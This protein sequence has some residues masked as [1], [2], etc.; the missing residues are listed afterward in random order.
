MSAHTIARE[1]D[2][3]RV[4][5]VLNAKARSVVEVRTRHPDAV[6]TVHT[7]NLCN[8]SDRARLVAGLPEQQQSRVG[9]LLLAVAAEAAASRRQAADA[10]SATRAEDSRW[11]ATE[12]HSEKQDGAKLLRDVEKVLTDH[13]ILPPGVA[14]VV[15]V[16]ALHTWC[17]DAADYTPYLWIR[18]PT[19]ECGKSTL[20][21]WLDVLVWK[22][23]GTNNASPA[24][25][26]RLIEKHGCTLLLDDIDTAYTGERRDDMANILN[27][28]FHRGSPV[29]RMEKDVTGQ[30]TDKEFATFGAKAIGGIGRRVLKGSTASRTIRVDMRRAGRDE[31]RALPRPRDRERKAIGAILRPRMMRWRDDNLAALRTQRPNIP[32]TLL[33]RASDMADPLLAIADLCAEEWP[34]RM[35][36]LLSAFM[37]HAVEVAEAT[38]H[39]VTLLRD[40]DALFEERRADFL[41]SEELVAGLK[42]LAERPWVDWNHGRGLSAKALADEL[43]EFGVKSAPK[44]SAGNRRGHYHSAIA[45]ALAAYA[46]S[47]PAPSAPTS[48]PLDGNELGRSGSPDPAAP[49]AL[50]VDSESDGSG[51]GAGQQC[52]PL[53]PK[54]LSLADGADGGDGAAGRDTISVVASPVDERRDAKGGSDDAIQTPESRFAAH[55]P[56]VHFDKSQP[57]TS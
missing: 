18:S 44:R 4:V 41:L 50:Q 33:G 7:I 29:F 11:L 48:P 42:A 35:R 36:G 46:P 21:E 28:G 2:E 19:P 26:Y 32:D 27:S 24:V 14:A 16:W 52:D 5:A 43:D 23:V 51:P 54:S 6:M 53:P 40:L 55:V 12:P 37:G 10:P 20:M 15:A 13:V 49:D 9:P 47:P 34:T 38:D 3:L 25:M 57:P 56:P 8:E 30:M 39:R 31:L 45:A 22:P 17:L 1:D